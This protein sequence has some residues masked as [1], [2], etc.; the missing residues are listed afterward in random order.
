MTSTPLRAI[1]PTRAHHRLGHVFGIETLERL[2]EV[3][4]ERGDEFWQEL[5]RQENL[6]SKSFAAIRALVPDPDPE[7]RRCPCC[8][9]VVPD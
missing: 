8:G 3:A 5:R 1:L 2:K 6:G 7:P 9:Q 4:A